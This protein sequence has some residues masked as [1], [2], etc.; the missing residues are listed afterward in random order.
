LSEAKGRGSL[1]DVAL[2]VYRLLFL[3]SLL[4][5]LPRYLRRMWQRGGYRADWPQRFAF[6]PALP[7]PPAG[8][9]R[10]WI[11]AVSVGELQAVG[12]LVAAL[13]AAGGW[14]IVLTTTTSTGYALARKQFANQV[15]HVGLFPL[16][17]APCSALAWR[18]LLPGL[19]VQLEGE[20][21]AE[22]LHRARRRGVPVVLANARLSDRTFARYE[23]SR[24]ARQLLL[25]PLSRILAATA[26][27]RD[28]FL[29]LG[30][31]AGRVELLG[32]LK[33]D[34]PLGDRLDPAGLAALR[35]ELGF[36][37]EA[38]KEPP[39]V[40]L[41]SSTWPGDEAALL[42]ALPRLRAGGR[43]VRLLLVPR[44][45]ERRAELVALLA[46]QPF[47]HHF[48]STAKATPCPV[49]VY[50]GDTTGELR[51]LTEVADVVV[52]G[53]SFAPQEGGQ[54]PV[55]AALLG[56]PILFGPRMS[57]FRDIARALVACGAAR[58]LPDRATL[59]PV[60]AEW[61][62]DPTA[63]ARAAT[64][65]ADLANAARGATTRTVEALERVRQD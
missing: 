8:V 25:R 49:D 13:H 1:L 55:E 26:Q 29:S 14:E 5:L 42:E 57:N 22:H 19:I 41:G 2:W 33:F 23:R 45:A 62:S 40:I 39:L 18:R 15:R 47:R 58:E 31:P 46:R 9:T 17:F 35:A 7:P 3:P 43:D 4:L 6:H 52:V 27:D 28:R 61:L 12:P 21:W 54:T 11:Q 10:L 63:R 24:F 48:R 32:S 20:L 30:V 50:V 38:D 53:K 60:L 44:H 59:G 56:K 65:A 37:P 36:G 64:A 51:R 16:D 34:A